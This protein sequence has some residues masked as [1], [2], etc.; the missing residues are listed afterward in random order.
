MDK[1]KSNMAQQVAQ[2]AVAFERQR[3]GHAPKPV[4]VVLSGETLVITLHGAVSHAERALAQNPSGA[5]MVQ[6]LHRQLVASASDSLRQEIKRLTGV[7]VREATAESEPA[8]G[9]GVGV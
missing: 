3:T 6:D 1:F 2:A 9:T 7:E 5:A 8:A 4:T